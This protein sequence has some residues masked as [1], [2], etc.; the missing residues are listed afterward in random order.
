MRA[1]QPLPQLGQSITGILR[2]VVKGWRYP[3]GLFK[4]V[5]TATVPYT[6]V[7]ESF[8]IT[9]TIRRRM[10][11]PYRF[12]W[13]FFRDI[14]QA[15]GAGGFMGFRLLENRSPG[16][17]H[18]D[19]LGGAGTPTRVPK[20]SAIT[21]ISRVGGSRRGT[22]LHPIHHDGC[23]GQPARLEHLFSGLGSRVRGPSTAFSRN[24]RR[25]AWLTWFTPSPAFALAWRGA[26]AWLLG[27]FHLCPS[28][29]YFS[30]RKTEWSLNPCRVL[31][32]LSGSPRRLVAGDPAAQAQS[33]AAGAFS[34]E[35]VR[36]VCGCAGA[37]AGP[38]V[39]VPGS[40][41]ALSP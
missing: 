5:V 2:L 22:R 27:S 39:V 36:R 16:V 40:W 34:G 41:A 35:A 3:H 14:R 37:P 18:T 1:R 9:F 6:H 17:E 33:A 10:P 31:L 12:F 13:G 15:I 38:Q 30:G 20:G 24:R 8:Q 26:L 19:F 25:A 11:T 32:L 21:C 23:R 7:F 28:L 29:W 4:K